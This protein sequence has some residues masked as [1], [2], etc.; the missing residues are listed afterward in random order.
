[1]RNAD[2]C[3]DRSTRSRVSSLFDK[4]LKHMRRMRP[5][6]D[7]SGE[8][9]FATFTKLFLN[10]TSVVRNS[11]Y[12][13]FLDSCP[14]P[15]SLSF[16]YFVEAALPASLRRADSTSDFFSRSFFSRS[17]RIKSGKRWQMAS[18]ALYSVAGNKASAQLPR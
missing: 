3:S 9:V 15:L 16:F 12:S 5:R 4:N 10:A 1:M 7:A 2:S 8:Q 13:K 6:D 11:S 17:L 14:L 18:V